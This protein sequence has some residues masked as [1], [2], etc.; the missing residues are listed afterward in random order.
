MILWSRTESSHCLSSS[1]PHSCHAHDRHDNGSQTKKGVARDLSG[2]AN[3][4]LPTYSLPHD[5]A[6]LSP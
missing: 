3:S 1:N 2:G 6:Y 5:N 4:H